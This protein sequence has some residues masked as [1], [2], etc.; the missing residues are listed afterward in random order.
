MLADKSNLTEILGS[1]TK[2]GDVI[3]FANDAP[4]FI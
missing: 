3:L 4:N 1:Q 2:A